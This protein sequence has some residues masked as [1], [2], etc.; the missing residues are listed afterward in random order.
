MSIVAIEKRENNFA[1]IDLDL[2][3]KRAQV[4]NKE[5]TQYDDLTT[6]Q[7]LI[8]FEMRQ[9]FVNEMRE[10]GLNLEI[11]RSPI[12]FD[13]PTEKDVNTGEFEAAEAQE[14]E[15]ET[16]PENGGSNEEENKAD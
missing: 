3:D 13:E 4:S 1:G 5:I 15:P 10:N 12:Y 2:I 11:L 14:Q 7:Y 8:M 9:R 16:A 6:Q